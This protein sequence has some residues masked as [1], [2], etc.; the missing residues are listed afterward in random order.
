MTSERIIAASFDNKTALMDMRMF[1]DGKMSVVKQWAPGYSRAMLFN[2]SGTSLFRTRQDDLEV[3]DLLLGNS[4]IL[5]SG[6]YYSPVAI[7][8]KNNDKLVAGMGRGGVKTWASTKEKVQPNLQF[9]L[10]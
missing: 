4:R 9:P 1:S 10:V 6:V 8:G 2:A 3:I 5:D 7:A